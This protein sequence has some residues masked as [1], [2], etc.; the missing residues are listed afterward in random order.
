MSAPQPEASK[1]ASGDPVALDAQRD[2][3]EVPA[4][5]PAGRPVVPAGDGHAAPRRRAQVLGEA[6]AVH[7]AESRRVLGYWRRS[8]T[9]AVAPASAKLAVQA[10]VGGEQ[11]RVG[12]RPCGRSCRERSAAAKS[13]ALGAGRRRPGAGRRWYLAGAFSEAKL[14][15]VGG[16]RGGSKRRSGGLDAGARRRERRSGP[17]RRTKF[18]QVSL[19]WRT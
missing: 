8:V 7:A 13:L 3:D 1:P 5:G 18:A 4:G 10:G 16:H 17:A 15:R 19:S 9:Q 6:L 12:R 14:A 2:P 11:R